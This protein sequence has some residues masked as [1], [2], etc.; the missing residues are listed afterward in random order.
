MRGSVAAVAVVVIGCGGPVVNDYTRAVASAERAYSAGRYEEAAREWARAEHA[1]VRTRDRDEAAYLE[2]AALA[3]AGRDADA[4]RAYGELVRRSPR[5]ERTARALLDRAALRARAGDAAGSFADLDAIVTDH[6]E[7]GAARAALA[8]CVDAKRRDGEGAVRTYLDERAAK[9]GAT[10]L[11]ESIASAYADSL[12]RSGD[13]EAA[14]ARYLDAANRYPYP[15]GRLWD[16]SLFHAAELAERLG[17]PS[18]AALLLERLLA[19]RETAYVQGSYERA[20][21]GEA[22][23]HLGE[24]YRDALRDPAKAR[25][26]F[27]ILF[28]EHRN[29]RLRDDGAWNAALLAR[30]AGDEAGAC[31]LAHGIVQELPES[32]YAAC[33]SHLCPAE[34]P[35]EKAGPCHE[36][37]LRERPP[38]GR[39]PPG[40]GP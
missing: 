39:T 38:G 11:G 24:L 14:K 31:R 35:P 27:E 26:E 16:D 5:G 1:A 22:R 17:N 6:P 32:R 7:S 3:R 8:A 20:R 21:Y 28:R 30:Q 2:A 25:A 36:Y 23:F 15:E 29:S 12:S 19:A 9:L 33:V 10:E 13:L 37:L 40:D 34:R 18:E 4:V